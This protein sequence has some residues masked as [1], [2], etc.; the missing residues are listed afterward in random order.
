MKD[1]TASSVHRL[2]VLMAPRLR[3]DRECG[4]VLNPAGVLGPGDT[5]YLLPRLVGRD[6]RSRIGLARVRRD[7]CGQPCSVQRLGIALEPG[8]PYE[9]P[10]S[11]GGGCE[12]A[13]VT[14]LA[15]SD[16]YLM[17]YVAVGDQGPRVAL[18]SSRDCRSWR[19]HGL[20]GL[21][22]SAGADVAAY[23]NKD[24]LLFPEPVRAPT[25][26]PAIALLHR[27]MYERWQGPRRVGAL[28][29]PAWMGDHRPSI[30]ISYCPTEEV[31]QVIAEGHT[32]V[33]GQHHLLAAPRAWWE[34]DRIGGGTVPL[35][36]QDGWLTIY[37]GVQRH[38]DGMRCYRA[39]GL[40]LDA[41]DPRR[42]LAR[43]W[44]PLFSPET[45][46]ERRGVVDNVVFPT[47]VERRGAGIDV[48]YG[49]ADRCVG[50]AHLV[51]DALDTPQQERVA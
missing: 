51:L 47:A 42:V 12:D 11:R 36:T 20:V 22:P 45:C 39:G 21:A 44:E 16:V 48:Y 31:R 7:R 29:P 9:C 27:P 17:T 40:L 6:T 1:L 24:A 26:E 10:A 33:F 2:G 23:A 34:D 28:P 3:R 13:R 49:M 43:S 46:A 4:G 19:R 30:W 15:A 35:R 32:P 5:F 14:H 37:H 18:A 8:A 38:A 50:V 41:D 25:G